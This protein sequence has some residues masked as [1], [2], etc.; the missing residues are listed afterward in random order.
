MTFSLGC[1]ALIAEYD[2]NIDDRNSAQINSG[3]RLINN[4]TMPAKEQ[5]QY[6]PSPEAQ[7]MAQV[8]NDRDMVSHTTTVK[9][10]AH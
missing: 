2:T 4:S 8:A 3:A 10:E 5:L 7:G 6:G 1:N 9:D